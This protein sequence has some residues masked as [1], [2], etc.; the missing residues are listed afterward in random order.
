MFWLNLK[1]VLLFRSLI[2]L[3][4]LSSAAKFANYVFELIGEFPYYL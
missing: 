1:I 2:N 4:D 3:I